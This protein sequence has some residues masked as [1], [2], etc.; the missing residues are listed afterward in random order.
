MRWAFHAPSTVG[1][2][3]EKLD[4]ACP[5]VHVGS[6]IRRSKIR[7]RRELARVLAVRFSRWYRPDGRGGGRRSAIGAC[8]VLRSTIEK[9]RTR[10]ENELAR[11][12]CRGSYR[13]DRHRRSG[14]GGQSIHRQSVR[15]TMAISHF[16]V[17]NI[18]IICDTHGRL[19]SES[20][21]ALDI[22]VSHDAGLV[23][24]S[25]SSSYILQPVNISWQF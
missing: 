16:N 14:S 17:Q 13:P 15:V 11:F 12:G 2:G 23:A 6:S 3:C 25:S 24:S 22:G 20:R 9:I 5:L 18:V 21:L 1:F 4:G 7:T 10:R 19:S 8:R